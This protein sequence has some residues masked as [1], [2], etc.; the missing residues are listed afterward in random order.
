MVSPEDDAELRRLTVT[1]WENHE[2]EID[3]TSYAEVV[4]APQGADEAHP[5]FSN[6]FVETEFVPE[7]GALLA[8]RLR[9][10]SAIE[11]QLW[12]AHL[13]TLEGETDGNLQYE[14][15]RARFV[16]RGRGVRSPLSVVDRGGALNTAGT[17]LDPILSLRQRV[18]IPARGAVNL[19]FTWLVA[20]SRKEA[21]EIAEKYRQPAT[22][23][24]ELL[25]WTQAYVQLQ[26]TSGSTATRRISS[27]VWPIVCST[28]IRRCVRHLR[29]WPRAA[30]ARPGSGPTASQA[31]S[32]SP[33][34]AS[35]PRRTCSSQGSSCEAHE[36]WY[37]KGI[38]ADLV[39]LNAQGTSYAPGL[40]GSIE[41][42]V[43]AIQSAAG[44]GHHP[45]HGGVFSIRADLLPPRD[46]ILL[47][48]AARVLILASRGTLSEQVV[49]LQRSRPGPVPPP[50]P[51]PREAAEAVSPPAWSS[52]SSMAWGDSH[53][54]AANTS[55][56]WVRA[57]DPGP[58]DK[59]GGQ[60]GV[61]F[62]GLRVGFGLYLVREQSG[63]QAHTV[64]E[65][66]CQRYPR[67]GSLCA[68]DEDSGL[69]WGPTALP[70]REDVW[71]YVIR[72]GSG[73]SRDR[74]SVT[75]SPSISCSWYRWGDPDQDLSSHSGK[76]VRPQTAALR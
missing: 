28:S 30:A 46:R 48:A 3:V 63:E 19:V 21:F 72:R 33:C 70:I 71:P 43:Q 9:P 73:Y 66:P 50:R 11:P 64:V 41:A 40:Q 13:S 38:A 68:R 32:R 36:Y 59:R 75:A 31:T 35:K 18:T 44:H 60:P 74:H 52:S 26:V 1:N 22:F 65:R 54:M 62:P 47:R 20:P 37:R 39:I 51:S 27:S 34:C 24:R 16:G 14:S 17:V 15:D 55:R 8:T 2:R 58:L 61:R 53:R 23:E 5:S 67:R 6:L 25:A 45:E 69:V 49:R 29:I 76:S 4:L 7:V 12:L 10:R 57:S 56:P 42:M